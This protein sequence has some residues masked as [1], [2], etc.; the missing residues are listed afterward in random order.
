MITIMTPL[1]LGFYFGKVLD[2]FGK[3]DYFNNASTITSTTA[4]TF[5]IDSLFTDGMV[6]F[7]VML[8][9]SI[10]SFFFAFM[11]LAFFND[12][13]ENFV[14]IVRKLLF[15]KILNKDV[16]YFDLPENK[17]GH[18]SGKLSKDSSVIRI[19]VSTYLGSILQALASFLI[20]VIFGFVYSWRITLLVIGL[21]PALF[22]SGVLESILYYGK[23]V[24]SATED[25]NMVQESFNNIKVWDIGY[26]ILDIGY[27][28]LGWLAI[29]KPCLEFGRVQQIE[30]SVQDQ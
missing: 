16:A 29:D 20:G 15:K 23:G 11:Q 12:V 7:Y 21:S 24:K 1:T 3:Y 4:V 17:P 5:T 25:Q 18:L 19:L 10:G 13:S 9:I 22:M 26:W 30:S 2:V 28:I 6:F 14:F 8:G 27:W